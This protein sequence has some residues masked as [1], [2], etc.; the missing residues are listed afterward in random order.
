MLLIPLLPGPMLAQIAP[1]GP[2]G[3]SCP[4][5]VPT[6][7]I[8]GGGTVYSSPINLEVYFCDDSF[9]QSETHWVKRNGIDVTNQLAYGYAAGIPCNGTYERQAAG[10]VSLT[11][12]A[13]TFTAGICNVDENCGSELEPVTYTYDATPPPVVSTAPMNEGYRRAALEALAGFENVITYTSPGFVFKDAPL[14]L[15]FVYRSGSAKPRILVQADVYPPAGAAAP[16]KYSMK[17]QLPGGAFATFL[18]TNTTEMFWTGATATRRLAGVIDA[19]SMSTGAHDLTLLVRS[20]YGLTVEEKSKTV[21]ALVVNES[22]NPIGRG[23]SIAGFQHAYEQTD[24]SVLIT[25]GD[26]SAIYFK[27]SGSTYITPDGDF[28]TL[29][30]VTG[31]KWKR[32]YPDGTIVSFDQYGRQTNVEDR[33]G[34][35]T[36]FTGSGNQLT[37]YYDLDDTNRKIVLSYTDTT[38][39]VTAQVPGTSRS[40][41]FHKLTTGYVHRIDDPD[42]VTGMKFFYGGGRIDEVYD[43][44]G[45]QTADLTNL[46]YDALGYLKLSKLPAIDVGGQSVRPE[47]EQ[48]SLAMVLGPDPASGLGSSGSPATALHPGSVKPWIEDP[49]DHRTSFTLDKFLAPKSI[50]EPLGRTTTFTRNQHA[51]V[52][53][54][55]TPAGDSTKYVWSGPRLASTYSQATGHA[56]T[57]QYAN[58]PESNYHQPI[59]I[60]DNQGNRELWYRYDGVDRL[61]AIYLDTIGASGVRIDSLTYE[62]DGRVDRRWDAGGHMRKYRYFS[63]GSRNLQHVDVHG[64]SDSLRTSHEYDDYG[65]RVRVINPA[66]EETEVAYDDLGRLQWSADA[67]GDTTHFAYDAYLLDTL[68]DARGK[69]HVALYNTLGQVTETTDPEGE[70]TAIGYDEAGNVVS[71]TD[72]M[73]RQA[74]FGY[75]ALNLPTFEEIEGDTTYLWVDPDGLKSAVRNAVSVDTTVFDG[76]GRPVKQIVRRGAG[77]TRR[78]VIDTW[79]EDD[80]PPWRVFVSSPGSVDYDMEF[81]WDDEGRLTRLSDLTPV[82]N[83]HTDLGYN[84]HGQLDTVRVQGV[85]RWHYDYSPFHPLGE[86]AYSNSTLDDA[87]GF[88]VGLDSLLLRVNQILWAGGDTTRSVTY[89]EIGQVKLVADSALST[90]VCYYGTYGFYCSSG[91]G[92][93]L[94]EQSFDY[95]PVGNPTGASVTDGNRLTSYQGYSFTHDDEGRTLTKSKA[96]FSQTY[97]WNDRSQ[98]DSVTTIDA[99]DTTV[100]RYTYDGLGRRITRDGPGGFEEYLYDGNHV[101]VVL[102]DSQNV[103]RRFSYYPGVDR[104]HSLMMNSG[105]YYYATDPTGSVSGLAEFTGAA[106]VTHRYRYDVWGKPQGGVTEATP[107][108]IR[109]KARWWDEDTGLADFRSRWYDPE[110]GRFISED[111]I[112]LAGGINVYR[113]VGNNPVSGWDPFGM[114]DPDDCPTSGEGGYWIVDPDGKRAFVLDPI[115]VCS[116]P[117]VDPFGG[118]DSFGDPIGPG[119]APTAGKGGPLGGGGSTGPVQSQKRDELVDCAAD[120]GL[121]AVNV[122]VDLSGLGALRFLKVGVGV[123]GRARQVASGAAAFGNLALAG[124]VAADPSLL[125]GNNYRNLNA[126]QGGIQFL[127]AVAT[128][129]E[130]AKGLPIVATFAQASDAVFSCGRFLTR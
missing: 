92:S 58:P 69:Q 120:L 116:S 20:H 4:E 45:W 56:I 107:N 32:T 48:R 118:G 16:D 75:D 103:L 115:G 76:A 24:G 80:G 111:P 59:S 31:G 119:P 90:P 66:D 57:Y 126:A 47:I 15:T 104:P 1:L 40:A 38:V 110:I 127:D 30:D 85:T 93:E 122:I 19:S 86:L 102:D 83:V 18:N 128:G 97:H 23:W 129:V 9:L 13:N 55:L 78:Y 123:L 79:Y 17:V 10:S 114:F 98:V 25:E 89:D 28:S 130:V 5:C 73:G 43:R 33:F 71:V 108:P 63:F 106:S 99:G 44:R 11:A 82:T 36:A 8:D 125:P 100:V 46:T 84:T 53:K 117:T 42:G 65:R 21:R 81:T 7:L 64:G 12:G 51:Q 50:E 70:T 72:R 124:A 60:S 52:T 49:L 88:G 37:S 96:G 39:T 27:K 121:V 54:L 26:G 68:T 113:F 62:T 91:G 22:N 34:N 67:L 87:L 101:I 74:S 61:T 77:F 3:G 14:D 29:E 95:D 2:G 6:V 94:S 35:E 105:T 109:F 41:V 112:G